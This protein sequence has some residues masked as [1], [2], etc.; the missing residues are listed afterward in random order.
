MNQFK[1]KYDYSKT[2]DKNESELSAPKIW[3][4]KAVQLS[5]SEREE[6]E[7]VRERGAQKEVEITRRKSVTLEESVRKA[8]LR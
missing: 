1:I 2:K 3:Y 5:T 7:Q 4:R 6:K 8:R